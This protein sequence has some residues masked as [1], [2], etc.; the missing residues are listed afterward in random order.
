M[1]IELTRL[2]L[3]AALIAIWPAVSAAE[4][5]VGTVISEAGSEITVLSYN[6]HGLFPLVAKDDPRDRMPTIGWLANRY[7]VAMFQE[8]FE[9]HNILRSQMP[10]TIGH[11][12][13]ASIRCGHLDLRSRVARDRR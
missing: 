4:P 3:C 13:L 5:E 8:D 6:V 9:Y 10:G 7:E 2:A 12:L 1:K 11:A